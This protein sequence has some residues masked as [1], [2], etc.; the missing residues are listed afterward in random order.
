MHESRGMPILALLFALAVPCLAEDD[1]LGCTDTPFLP[2]SPWRVHDRNRPHP[3]MIEPGAALGQPPAD[4]IIL[5]DGKD[6]SQWQGDRA[7]IAAGLEDGCINILKAGELRTKAKFG[8]CQLHIEWATPAA[9]DTERRFWW[10]NS[11]IFLLDRYEV[12]VTESHANVHKAD[13]QAGAIYGQTPPLVNVARK[14]GEWQT[15]DIVFIAPRFDG[16]KL[17]APAFFTVFWNGVLA[18]YHTECMGSTKYKTVPKYDSFDMVGPIRLQE[19]GSAVRYR[20]IW[21]RPLQLPQ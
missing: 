11:G 2:N 5:F 14:P 16:E 3:P 19:H 13:G 8:D 12:Q 21:I 18:Q 10:G 9:R 7:D 4:A 17:I 1:N 15:Y 20:N 6:L